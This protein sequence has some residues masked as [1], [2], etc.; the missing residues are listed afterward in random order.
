MRSQTT[1]WLG[2]KAEFDIGERAFTVEDA[3]FLIYEQHARG[4]AAKCSQ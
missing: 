4:S 2:D 3:S 1:A